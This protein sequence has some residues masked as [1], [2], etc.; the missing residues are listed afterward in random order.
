M[1]LAYWLFAAAGGRWL[2]RLA[3]CVPY[4]VAIVIYLGIRMSV[5]G[6]LVATT[7]F[8]DISARLAGAA[9][10]LLGE[11]AKLFF[12]P[13][14]LDVFRT[15]DL[16]VALRSPWPWVTLVTLAATLWIRRREPALSFVVI[17]W[18]VALVPCL[19]IRQLTIPLIADRFS[20]L[21]SVGLCFALAYLG[22]KW[23]PARLVTW[24]AVYVVAPLLALLT[25]FWTV[26]SVHATA[27]WHNTESLVSHALTEHPDAA[28]PHLIKGIRM[29]YQ[30]RDF[31]GAA[32]EYQTALR[33]NRS[34]F[35]PLA[36]VDSDAHLGLGQIAYLRGR[37]QEAIE[38]FTEVARTSPSPSPAY[39]AL[40]SIFF[41]KRDYATGAGYF[42]QAV[43]ANPQELGGRF[44]LGTC[45]MKMGKYR[46]AAEQFRAARELDPA[47][48]QY[49]EAEAR[50]LEAAGDPAGA[51]RVRGLKPNRP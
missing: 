34:S 26:R 3:R 13:L 27:N 37:T 44:Y 14:K 35:R 12:W 39:D 47:E 29:Q 15:F 22:W 2:S 19:D 48:L 20:Y 8:W 50:A 10:G 40:G 41:S 6:H 30:Q 31:D 49:Y 28:V 23:L 38:I 36:L 4:I 16:G 18:T 51:A 24:R 42:E 1:L 32:R 21:P 11:H 43:K 45:W 9:V 46:E 33:L 7:Q 5:L 25:C 17:W